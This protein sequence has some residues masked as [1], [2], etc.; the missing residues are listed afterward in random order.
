MTAAK[1]AT[2]P[3]FDLDFTKYTAD[4]KIP[5]VDVNEMMAFQRKNMEA[6]TKANKVAFDGFQAVAQRQGEIF[7]SLLDKVQTQGKDFAA[8]SADDPM[9]SAAKQTEV[10]KAA[11]EEALSNAKELSGLVTKSQEEALSLLQTRFTDSLDEF[12]T[13][14]EKSAVAK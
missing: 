11:Y 2:N 12:K 5:G 13:V 10:A 7:K 9:A 1:K 3:F 6:L 4:F 14:I 8:T